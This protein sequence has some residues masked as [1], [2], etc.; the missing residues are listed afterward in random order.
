MTRRGLGLRSGS[1]GI[2]CAFSLLMAI[3]SGGTDSEQTYLEIVIG[4]AKN[5]PAIYY[6]N[7]GRV[8]HLWQKP[9]TEEAQELSSTVHL[10]TE[11]MLERLEVEFSLHNGLVLLTVLDLSRWHSAFASGRSG[12]SAKLDFLQRHTRMLFKLWRTDA[13]VGLSQLDGGRC[14]AGAKG[15]SKTTGLSG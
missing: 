13:D 6:H 1:W 9:S 11:T 2:V 4:K 7:D 10:V 8:L 14:K 15:E 5:V 3:E 12:D